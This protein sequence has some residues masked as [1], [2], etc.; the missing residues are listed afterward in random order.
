M[1]KTLDDLLGD[2]RALAAVQKLRALGYSADEV[3]RTLAKELAAN[4]E[5]ERGE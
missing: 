1:N 2:N 4:T 5:G 3:A